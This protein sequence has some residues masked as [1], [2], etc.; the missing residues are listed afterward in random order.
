LSEEDV[1]LDMDEIVVDVIDE[2]NS[3]YSDGDEDSE[4]SGE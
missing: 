3:E 4:E 2:E 1:A